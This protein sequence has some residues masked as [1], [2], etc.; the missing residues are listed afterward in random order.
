LE[1]NQNMGPGKL[2]AIHLGPIGRLRHTDMQIRL[3]DKKTWLKET[4]ESSKKMG[5]GKLA[6]IQL[7]RIVSLR[8]TDMKKKA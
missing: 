5:T 8:R 3:T 6:V 4:L 7:G 1:S 2:R